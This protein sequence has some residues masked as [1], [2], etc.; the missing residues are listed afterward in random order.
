MFPHPKSEKCPVKKIHANILRSALLTAAL[1]SYSGINALESDTQQEITWSSDGGSSMSLIDGNRVWELAENVI[2]RQGTLEIV[3][4]R[5]IIELDGSSN[6][7][8]RVT[9]H[10]TPVRYQQQL[11]ESGTLVNGSSL[12]IEF[13]EDS[14]DQGMVIDLIGEAS[15]AS[16]DTTM[17]CATITYL[18]DTDLIRDAQGPCQGSL[19]QSSSQGSSQ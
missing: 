7:L 6:D 2:I 1:T 18:A 15:I 17:R 16:P 14:T 19:S 11:D 13:Y 12:T 3:G 9:V 4:D 5:A 8:R 10:G